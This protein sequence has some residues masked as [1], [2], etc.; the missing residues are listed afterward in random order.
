MYWLYDTYDGD[1][2]LL[3]RFDTM[4]EVRDVCRKR[5]EDTDGEWEPLLK[6]LSSDGRLSS[7]QFWSY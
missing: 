7:V 4:D 2:E 3:G 5:D 6:E 1:E